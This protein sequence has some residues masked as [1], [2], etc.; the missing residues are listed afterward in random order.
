LR[1]IGRPRHHRYW[2][3]PRVPLG[4]ALV[5]STHHT[6]R[7]RR[8]HTEGS[9][10]NR[11]AIQGRH[12]LLRPDRLVLTRSNNT[13]PGGNTAWARSRAGPRPNLDPPP[14]E[15]NVPQTTRPAPGGR[16]GRVRRSKV[17][18]DSTGRR[19]FGASGQSYARDRPSR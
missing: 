7:R 6:V 18:P 14:S 11:L 15:G 9:C 16:R 8:I 17:L 10:G 13:L 1:A 2:T 4:S 19:A 3:K 12:R 5:A